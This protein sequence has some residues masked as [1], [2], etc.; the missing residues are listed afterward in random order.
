LFRA[1]PAATPWPSQTRKPRRAEAATL[2]LLASACIAPGAAHAQ[3]TGCGEWSASLLAAEGPVDI[4]HTADADWAAAATSEVLCL[5]DS[6]RVGAY[7]RAAV[8][9]PDDTVLRLDQFTTVTF[10]PPEDTKRSWLEVL[11]GAIHIISRDPRAL[12]VTTPFANA[13]IE[14]TEFSVVVSDSQTEVAVLEGTV[15]LSNAAGDIDI[16]SQQI[17]SADA[18]SIGQPRTLSEPNR[19]IDWTRYFPL[20]LD[21]ALPAPDA[22]V[23]AEPAQLAARAQRRLGVG[24]VVEADADVTRALQIDPAS[25]DARAVGAL[26][27]LT[28]N[29]AK[30]AEALLREPLIAA[31][32]P[33]PV[34]LAAAIIDQR[35]GRNDAGLERLRRAAAS[36]PDNGLVWARLAEAQLANGNH[37]AALDAA[38]RADALDPSKALAQ[39]ATGFAA[40]EAGD[41]ARA[42]T[43]F[44]EA[45]D[46]EPGMP[47]GHLGL[48]L[49]MIRN[50][51]LERG[52]AE[53]E[54]AVMLDAGNGLVRSYMAKAYYDENRGALAG[55][56]LTAAKRL[57]PSDPTPWLYDAL[58]KQNANDPV[59]AL[60]D[61]HTAAALN[62]DRPLFRS[63]L[64]VDED[65]AVRGAG[66]ARIYRSLGFEQLALERGSASVTET[67]EDFSGHQ[68]LG[69]IYS[70]LPRH[71]IARVNELYQAQ[72]LRP[73]PLASTQAQ[74]G[75]ANLFM[76][77]L[78]GPSDLAHLEL[79]PLVSRDGVRFQA[80]GIT[81]DSGTRGE[82]IVVS[83]SADRFDFNAG[84]FH[85][86]TDGYRANSDFS[87]DLLS[88]VLQYRSSER[89]NL[90]FEL[91][92]T[93][94]DRGDLQ[95]LF[96]PNQFI[97]VQRRAESIDTLRFGLRREL[98]PNS[99]L[100]G[101]VAYSDISATFAAGDPI[102]SAATVDTLIGQLQ[103]LYDGERWR[104]VSGLS[105][106][107]QDFAQLTEL[108]F[109]VPFPPF[110]IEQTETVDETL[111]FVS[112]YSYATTPIGQK[113]SL[114]AGASLDSLD[115]QSLQ[116][117]RF[118]PKLGLTWT[119][120]ADTTV[121]ATAFKTLHGPVVSKQIIQ[122]SLEPTQVNGFNQFFYG[123]EGDVARR[124]GLA[125]DHFV[126]ADMY[127]GAEISRRE[128]ETPVVL[129]AGPQSPAT[130]F[131]EQPI[132]E[133][134]LRS[135]LYWTPHPRVALS[136]TFERE[137]IDNNGEVLAEGFSL[138]R[139]E[140]LP[141]SAKYFS[142][143]GFSAGFTATP[144]DQRGVFGGPGTP[145]SD[146]GERFWVFDLSLGYR[147]PNRH[148]FVELTALNLADEHFRYQ[149]TDPETPRILP[150]RFVGLRFTVSY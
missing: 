21:G 29:S 145:P 109:E 137:R 24:R 61:L 140:R 138:L 79:D 133:S 49:T 80:S 3:R 1:I 17:A 81:G 121:R 5:G 19:L 113:V 139:T 96:D 66:Q 57:D 31:S 111:R 87:Q 2:I 124:V 92:S 105:L 143:S 134:L 12:R 127:V 72:L 39:V 150:F 93:E 60:G 120:T 99:V 101:S 51:D 98:S 122:P 78:A 35:Q 6:L 126:S 26:I 142:P 116:R 64:D 32:P 25:A 110:S 42:E 68:L 18:T 71:Q 130:T 14:G 46:R 62:D 115:G 86:G 95:M 146:D 112:L 10:T 90:Q 131:V 23:G 118:N 58:R 63:R 125:V 148:G 36:F 114:T 44:R 147:L 94:I 7:G 4:R 132:D 69:D 108:S 33:A 48:A 84:A 67:P 119:P 82:T 47:L 91:R 22:D 40:L 30:D 129:F 37:E 136:A 75:E 102:N 104:I 73:G 54:N 28:A 123:S 83:G 53:I 13:G 20:V 43:A 50:G 88:A 11:A 128:I 76:L 9:L 41:R 65:L 144:V 15:V 52:R 16:A 135:Y 59:A 56:Q 34:L 70:M 103:H 38:S 55:S 8:M 45:I 100:L 107:S 117:D 74:L 141:M 149:D 77:N 27:A 97:P 106:Q 89:T 85:Y